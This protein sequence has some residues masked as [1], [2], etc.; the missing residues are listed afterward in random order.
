MSDALT[1]LAALSLDPAALPAVTVSIDGGT[2]LVA[3]R[4]EAGTE[5]LRWVGTP[6]EWDA[7][8]LAA[9]DGREG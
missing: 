9:R 4:D 2:V 5:Q 7:A 6:A 3:Q 8:L 1:R